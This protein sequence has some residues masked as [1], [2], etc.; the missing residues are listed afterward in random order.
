MFKLLL[1]WE[2]PECLAER[3]GD[4]IPFCSAWR[5]GLLRSRG[6]FQSSTW[7]LRQRVRTRLSATCK[8]GA[9]PVL[10]RQPSPSCGSQLGIAWRSRESMQHLR[11]LKHRIDCMGKLKSRGP[12]LWDLC[13]FGSTERSPSLWHLTWKRR[14]RRVQPLQLRQDL[15]SYQL[16]FHQAW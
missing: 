13:T 5:P 16:W 9:H 8:W 1:I 2:G 6:T 7:A 4:P 3:T 12:R 11:A 10:A 15:R 14:W